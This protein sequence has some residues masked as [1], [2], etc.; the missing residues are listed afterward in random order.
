M[1]QS[2]EKGGGGVPWKKVIFGAEENQWILKV[3]FR[4]NLSI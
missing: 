3:S 2:E 1:R 4:S